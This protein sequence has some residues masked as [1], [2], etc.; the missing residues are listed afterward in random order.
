MVWRQGDRRC[1]YDENTMIENP[2]R[3]LL[4]CKN[5]DRVFTEESLRD[6]DGTGKPPE[7][8]GHMDD[9]R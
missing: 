2:R 4:G 6:W 7:P 3:D 5:C 9:F 1:P 8:F